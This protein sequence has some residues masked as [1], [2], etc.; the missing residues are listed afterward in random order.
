MQQA[1]MGG[2]QST[3]DTTRAGTPDLQ[4]KILYAG[5]SRPDAGF[6]QAPV[7]PVQPENIQV[8][9]EATTCFSP[10]FSEARHKSQLKRPTMSPVCLKIIA[11]VSLAALCLAANSDQ[12]PIAD[13]IATDSKPRKYNI[14]LDVSVALLTVSAMVEAHLHSSTTCK[15][16]RLAL[17]FTHLI[18]TIQHFTTEVSTY[19]P[20]PCKTRSTLR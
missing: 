17:A 10:S 6:G 7:S 16:M 3:L 9:K 5:Q 14:T 4:P 13:R 12:Q 8:L 18:P 19:S 11:L 20:S 15:A 1:W 2:P